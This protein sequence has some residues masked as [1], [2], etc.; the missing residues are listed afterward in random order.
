MNYMNQLMK[1]ENTKDV[2]TLY[3]KSL[4]VTAG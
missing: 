1:K 4:L 3:V 2:Q